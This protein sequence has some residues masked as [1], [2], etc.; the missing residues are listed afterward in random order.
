LAGAA[1]AGPTTT[2]TIAGGTTT[3]TIAGGTTTTT[4]TTTL[5]PTTTTTAPPTTTTTAPPTTT[6]TLPGL[7]GQYP[8]VDKR[9]GDKSLSFMNVDTTAGEV[10]LSGSVEEID[11]TTTFNRSVTFSY[12]TLGPITKESDK[13][14]QA[15]FKSVSVQ[16]TLNITELSTGGTGGGPELEYLE[17][18]TL[19]NADFPVPCKAKATLKQKG[20]SGSTEPAQDK[21]R[22]SCELGPDLAAFPG[23]SEAFLENI[24]DAFLRRKTLKVDTKKG[25]LKFKT[26]G[27]ESLP[28]DDQNVPLSCPSP[29]P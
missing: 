16:L 20:G 3:T 7:S 8:F 28:S 17:T 23:L 9:F 1:L 29:A 14:V 15:D 11:P 10:C 18:I 6:T 27:I 12:E 19:P 13:S 5:T 22:L 25:K 4:T 2:T 24:E 21:V 26:T